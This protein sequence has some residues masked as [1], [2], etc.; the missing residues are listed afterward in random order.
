MCMKPRGSGLILEGSRDRRYAEKGALLVGH[1]ETAEHIRSKTNAT[2]NRL[3]HEARSLVTEMDVENA[4][5]WKLASKQYWLMNDA[6][7]LADEVAQRH[8][9]DDLYIAEIAIGAEHT[10][11]VIEGLEAIVDLP[12]AEAMLHFVRRPVAAAMLHHAGVLYP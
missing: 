9:R 1:E 12:L 7:L 5:M 4:R 10:P 6:D 2:Y 3:F 11:V 8:A